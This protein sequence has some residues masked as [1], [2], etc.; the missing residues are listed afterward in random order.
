M[1]NRL[2]L[3]DAQLLG[4]SMGKN[5]WNGIIDLVE[6]MG[7]TRAEWNKWKDEYPSSLDSNDF[8]AIEEH[9]EKKLKKSKI[10]L[11]KNE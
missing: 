1:A 7:L 9:F 3:A 2:D 5:N 4:F 8:D 10:I 11:K 6:S